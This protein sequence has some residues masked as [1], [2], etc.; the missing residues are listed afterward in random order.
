VILGANILGLGDLVVGQIVGAATAVALAVLVYLGQRLK[1]PR[2]GC[3]RP[4]SKGAQLPPGDNSP[5]A[6]LDP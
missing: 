3:H 2:S 5:G 1:T 4:K 6:Q